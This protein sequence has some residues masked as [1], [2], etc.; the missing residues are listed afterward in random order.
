M[1]LNGTSSPSGKLNCTEMPSSLG[2]EQGALGCILMAAIS[3]EPDVAYHMLSQ[4]NSD[5]FFD[6]R[7]REILKA[8]QQISLKGHPLDS[9]RVSRQLSSEFLDVEYVNSLAGDIPSQHQF[10]VYLE[11]IKN[12]SGRRRLTSFSQTLQKLASDT[13]TSLKDI[14]AELPQRL[15]EVLGKHSTFPSVVN[16]EEFIQ[17]NIATPPVIIE[18]VLHQGCKLLVSGGS[19]SNKTWS[20]LDMAISLANGSRWLDLNT[21]KC[22]VLYVNMEIPEHGIQSRIKS[23]LKAKNTGDLKNL[24]VLN[25]RGYSAD[26]SMLTSRI[27][28][29]AKR[30]EYGLVIIDP[31]YKLYGDRDENSVSDMTGI[32]NEIDVIARE[33]GAAVA[34]AAH[35]TKGNQAGKEA[36]DR[37][38]GSGVFARDVDAMLVFTKHSQKDCFTVS[39]ILR[40]MAPNE[41]FVVK[42]EYPLMELEKGLDPDSIKQRAN[43][44]KSRHVTP[45][46]LLPHVAPNKPICKNLLREKANK[47]GIAYGKIN[48]LIESAIDE[49][50]LFSWEESRSG[51]RPRIII[52]REPKPTK[53]IQMIQTI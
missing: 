37:V 17:S 32:L 39:S 3:P 10:P 8:M 16:G 38:A 14:E 23:V 50:K 9:M 49:G 12:V 48:G 7:N 31:I 36:I 22:N 41:D 40:N 27:R 11:G 35:Q 5:D 28:G 43:P 30:K 25:L 52:S 29:T 4:L 44:N 20:L 24:D 47:A 51:T 19:K 2:D 1:I 15:Q 26:I 45:E 34:F 33:S 46:D 6:L 53:E 42:W 13:N 21:T 18:G